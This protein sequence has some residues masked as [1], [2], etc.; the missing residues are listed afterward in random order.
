[1][2]INVDG[3]ING[4]KHRYISRS[5]EEAQG[6]GADLLVIE[7][8]TP[9]GLVDSTRDIVAVLLESPVPVAVYVSPHGARAGS[10]GTFITAAGH[11]AAMAPGTNI[12]AATPVSGTGEALEETL[13]S[14]VEN[15]AAALIRS[16]AQE[17]GRN[18]DALES[19]VRE[20]ASFSA[21]EALELDIIDFVVEDLDHLLR[22][23]DGH[24]VELVGEP[25]GR[26]LQTENMQLR[27]LDKNL[28][29]GFLEFIS[30]PNVSFLLLTIGG[31]GIVFELFSPGLIVPGVTGVICLLLALLA[32]GNL[33]VNWAAAA[34]I[35]LAVILAVLET[36]VCRLWG[37]GSGFHH[38][39]GVG[40]IAAVHPVWRRVADTAQ[41]GCQP[42]AVGGDGG[43]FGA[44]AHLCSLGDLFSQVQGPG[45][46]QEN[47]AWNSSDGYG[48]AEPYRRR[49]RRK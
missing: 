1:M 19:T 36:Q 17:R 9:G 44:R 37:V 21:N 34:F 11:V 4:V 5:I 27:R 35:L 14:K 24:R 41:S 39:P 46:D 42:L 31:L 25:E 23:I 7:L 26:V 18:Q 32:F 40:R 22:Q 45:F 10:A 13:A 47:R 29:E 30:D 43:G 3:I 15:D 16:I 28:L 33:P 6:T 20:A 38:Q 2:V 48:S 12:G 8:D 49:A